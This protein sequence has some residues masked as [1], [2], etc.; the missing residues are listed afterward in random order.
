VRAVDRI[1]VPVSIRF[2]FTDLY[3]AKIPWVLRIKAVL[4]YRYISNTITRN[5]ISITFQA[6]F[7]SSHLRRTSRENARTTRAC[8]LTS[9]VNSPPGRFTRK[10]I[11][12]HASLLFICACVCERTDEKYRGTS[13]AASACTSSCS[14]ANMTF[15]SDGGDANKFD[16]SIPPR[17]FPGTEFSNNT[18]I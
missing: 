7:L 16:S 6:P 3:N 10:F 13:E 15:G 5:Y 1:I 17:G 9:H 2:K 8:A 18:E 14:V 4:M 12:E 11:V